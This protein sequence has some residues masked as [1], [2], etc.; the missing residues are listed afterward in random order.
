MA[1]SFDRA[2]VERY[3][4]RGPRYTS[5]PTALQFAESYGLAQFRRAAVWKRPATAPLSLYVHIPFCHSLCYYC[6]CTK[7]VTQRPQRAERY[8]THLYREIELYDGL[9]NERRPVTQLHFGGGT[10]TYIGCDALRRLMAKL[11]V[12]FNLIDDP[13][14]EYSIEIDPRTVNTED[15]RA[16]AEMGFNRLSLG[17]QDFDPEVQRS[18]NRLQSYDDTL[19][20][21]EAARAAGFESISLDLIYGLPRQTPESFAVT[22]DK[23]LD[24][25]PARLAVYSYAHLPQMF[26]AQ[27]MIK[28]ESLCPPET[29]LTLMAQTVERLQGAG[30][31]YIGMDHFALPDD[32]LVSA[33]SSGD[34]HR[35]FQGYST[36]ARTD[37]IGLGMS[38]ISDLG[39]AYSQNL[40]TLREYGDAINELMCYGRLDLPAL[41]RRFGI[42]AQD[43]LA[44]EIEAL[45]PLADDGLIRVEPSRVI[46]T[47]AG[48]LLLRPIAMVFDQYLAIPSQTQRHSKVI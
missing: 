32:D 12:H 6:G 27:R 26:K 22:L 3:E 4:G 46:V 39:N 36:H 35:N 29:K 37:L 14:R 24:I 34:L 23:V 21:I 9:V 45:A 42:D 15:P 25:R 18:V 11:G 17:V 33:Q 1:V 13:E 7:V 43:Y 8:L 44:A 41:G 2:L 19:A 31:V 10:P 20:L 16:W 40:K 47:D 30:Y 48:R 28:E 5:Y 38:A